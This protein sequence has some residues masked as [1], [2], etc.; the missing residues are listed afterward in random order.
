M[1]FS[2]YLRRKKGFEFNLIPLLDIV[3]ILFFFVMLGVLYMSNAGMKVDLPKA[4]TSDAFNDNN[5]VIISSENI[6]YLGNKVV[7][8][9][10]LKDLLMTPQNK[11]RPVLIKADRRASFGRIVDVWDL[12]RR[13]GVGRINVISD[14]EQ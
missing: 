13:M 14:Q 9:K 3:F 4:I 10:D 8:L 6:L 11:A 12:G 7:T 5:I 1:D 2:K